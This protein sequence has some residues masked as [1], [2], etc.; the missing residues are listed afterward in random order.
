MFCKLRQASCPPSDS[1]DPNTET[2][3][4][5]SG[6]WECEFNGPLAASRTPSPAR[7][8]S[9]SIGSRG[10]G[11]KITRT[12]W[13][14]RRGGRPTLNYGLSIHREEM[15]STRH[16]DTI[17]YQY[18]SGRPGWCRGGGGGGLQSAAGEASRHPP[19][20]LGGTGVWKVPSAPQ[21]SP[22]VAASRGTRPRR[23]S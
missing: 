12:N 6:S 17:R 2:G 20:S 23:R 15:N 8:P 7:A 5:S 1:P 14:H 3:S 13:K 16:V 9:K 11:D 18:V 21:S 4:Y 22:R 19:R 10:R